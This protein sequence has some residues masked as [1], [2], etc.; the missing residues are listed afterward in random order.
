MYSETDNKYI[1]YWDDLRSSGK[2]D[3]TNI[4]VQ[5]VTLSLDDSCDLG[6][7]NGD[8]ILN[9]IDIVNLVNHVL[10]IAVLDDLCP[11]DLNADG[12]IDVIDVVN[13]VN[14]ILNQ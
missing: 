6:D 1:I 12:A 4:Y 14:A 11:A 10:S 2:E 13:L 9:V 5:S 7:V 8:G 3:L